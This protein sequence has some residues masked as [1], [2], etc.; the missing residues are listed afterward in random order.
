MLALLEQG[1]FDLDNCETAF[2]VSTKDKKIIQI[3]IPKS[4]S[5][6]VADPIYRP[7]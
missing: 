6:A 1:E 5:T 4:Y 7:E 2:A 3:P